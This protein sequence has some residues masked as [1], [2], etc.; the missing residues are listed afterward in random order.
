MVVC[1]TESAL[2][3]RWSASIMKECKLF[4]YSIIHSTQVQACAVSMQTEGKGQ[5]EPANCIIPYLGH[6]QV[7]PLLTSLTVS[8][9][10]ALHKCTKSHGPRSSQLKSEQTTLSTMSQ[11]SKPQTTKYATHS[12]VSNSSLELTDIHSGRTHTEDDDSF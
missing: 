6:A 7:K 9:L 8:N 11:D 2:L 12:Y 5:S 3:M 4:P 1:A 10:Q